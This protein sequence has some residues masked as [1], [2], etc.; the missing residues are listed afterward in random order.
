MAQ[1]LICRG[2]NCRK[3]REELP[4]T[5]IFLLRNVFP[6]AR[7]TERSLYEQKRS[8]MRN[9]ERK[10]PG[11]GYSRGVTSISRY[12]SSRSNQVST[13]YRRPTRASRFVDFNLRRLS[14]VIGRFL[15]S[16]SLVNAPHMMTKLL[17]R[18]PLDHYLLFISH[19]RRILSHSSI[20]F[21]KSNALVYL[22][23]CD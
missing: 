20:S 2:Q 1:I 23:S 9:D 10:K 19:S 4:S 3:R 13:K 11:N 18:Y 7:R 22:I 12:W 15:V 14:A 16:V 5:N 6:S 8:S 17:P 21:L